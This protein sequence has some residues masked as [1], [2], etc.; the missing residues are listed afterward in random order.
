MINQTLDT[1]MSAPADEKGPTKS[2]N[3]PTSWAGLWFLLTLLTMM[4]SL[5]FLPQIVRFANG[6]AT[7]I[8]GEYLGSVQKVDFIGGLGHDTQVQTETRTVLIRGAVELANGTKLE[9]RRTF[10]TDDV[11]EVGTNVCRDLLSE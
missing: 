5:I 2:E 7:P 11:C 9:R 3:E 1:A 10:L 8:A 6:I 4:L